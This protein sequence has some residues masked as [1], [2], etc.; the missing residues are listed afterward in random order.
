MD[1][2]NYLTLYSGGID[3]TL[4]IYENETAKNLIH[5]SC[6]NPLKT[7][8]ANANA[9]ALGRT[10]DTMAHQGVVCRDGEVSTFHSLLDA[11]MILDASIQ[12]VKYGK[13]G[14]I[15]GFN[16]DDIGTDIAA[17]EN[18]IKTYDSGFEILMPYKNRS[19]ADIRKAFAAT[20]LPA[21]SCMISDACG[22]CAKCRRG[23]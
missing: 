1:F 6:I 22:K 2:S 4:F 23:Y 18:I 12:A 19:A 14:V 15:V 3:S 10:I 21:I 7:R 9:H 16:A 13:K 8:V 20:E 11:Q 5:Y 17:L